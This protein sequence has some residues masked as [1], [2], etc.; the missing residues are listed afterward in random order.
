[1]DSGLIALARWWILLSVGTQCLAFLFWWC[2]YRYLV[3]KFNWGF[4]KWWHY[5]TIKLSFLWLFFIWDTFI[6]IFSL[7]LLFDFT[8]WYSSYRKQRIN[9]LYIPFNYKYSK[10]W[11]FFIIL[12]K[13]PI[14]LLLFTTFVNLWTY[15][16]WVFQIM[17][18]III[19]EAKYSLFLASLYLLSCCLS[20]EMT[21]IVI[22]SF[23][24]VMTKC[25]R[26]ILYIVYY[27]TGI[28]HFS[29]DVCFLLVGNVFR[30]HNLGTKD[31]HCYWVHHCFRFFFLQRIKWGNTDT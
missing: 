30:D 9:D 5:K 25:Y 3:P 31:A 4:R 7:H 1:M 14:Q 18:I 11:W 21:L 20:P 22:D 15:S 2:N 29:K 16:Y 10:Q 13:W 26:F 28:S 17:I 27:R 6:N 12:Q 24:T 19:F 8:Q 23:L